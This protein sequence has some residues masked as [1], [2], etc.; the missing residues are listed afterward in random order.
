[1]ASNFNPLSLIAAPITGAFQYAGGKAQADAEKQASQTQNAFNEKA[2]A[3]AQATQDWQKQQYNNYLTQQR[4]AYLAQLQPF[5]QAGVQAGQTLSSLL[6]RSPYAQSAG[7]APPPQQFT[8]P[9]SSIGNLA[10][11]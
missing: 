8:L 7:Q 10:T 1:M 5:Q 11:K 4:P 2:L 9:Q 6:A 3:A